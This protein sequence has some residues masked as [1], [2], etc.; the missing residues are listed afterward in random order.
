M[1]TTTP[2][3]A[4]AAVHARLVG[5]RQQIGVLRSLGGDRKALG[6]AAQV[7]STATGM[8]TEAGCNA[9]IRALTNAGKLVRE[10]AGDK[11]HPNA[12]DV[13]MV[14]RAALPALQAIDWH[15]TPA[16]GKVTI[17]AGPGDVR[18]VAGRPT[19]VSVALRRGG[20]LAAAAS[21]RWRFTG[22]G[23]SALS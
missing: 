23:P 10:F 19:K 2:T 17:A 7:A 21:A 11:A 13:A 9:A 4:L 3:A 5:V 18:T 12:S 15:V 20:D 6:D 16:P 1:P 8:G 22:L 14:C